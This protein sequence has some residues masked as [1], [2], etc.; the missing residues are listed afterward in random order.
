NYVVGLQQQPYFYLSPTQ[1]TVDPNNPAQN[2]YIENVRRIVFRSAF[3]QAAYPF[4]RFRR[5]E[6]GVEATHL[7][8]G[9]RQFITPYDPN[10]G[11]VTDNTRDNLVDLPG[12]SFVRPS[13]ALT[14]DNT[15]FGY[16]GPYVGRR[17]RVEVS[18]AFGDWKVTQ[19]SADYRR[20]DH[21]VGPFVL[22][23]RGLFIGRTQTDSR[24][25]PIFLGSTDLLRGHTSGSYYRHECLTANDPSTYSGCA[26]LDQLIGNSIGLVS[27]ELRFPLLNASL[28]FLPVGFPPIEGAFFYDAG[29]AWDP[30]SV[31]EWSRPGNANIVRFREPL[32]TLGF[33]IRANVLGF[34]IL[35]GDYSVPQHRNG[36][37]GYWTL[38]IGP[39]W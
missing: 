23:T 33:S 8:D 34:L 11:I 12:A 32:Q 20:Y 14:F 13:L 9:I 38:S 16:V 6:A 4:S 29:V 17:S 35:R 37:G 27:G 19:L 7:D 26:Q 24:V 21:L 22:A 2:L 36:I 25:A 3:A 5:I 28:G 15:I 31:V 39:T 30:N 18:K 10:S 1:I